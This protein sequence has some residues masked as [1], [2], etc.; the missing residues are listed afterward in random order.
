M[1]G[2]PAKWPLQ[3]FFLSFVSLFFCLDVSESLADFVASS[4]L[5]IE[6]QKR[7]KPSNGFSCRWFLL[8]ELQPQI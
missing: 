2:P 1:N 6:I 8:S 3:L 5:G 7:D 4:E